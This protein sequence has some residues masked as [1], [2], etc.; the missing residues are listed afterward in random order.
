V[1]D[2]TT[3]SIIFIIDEIGM[4]VAAYFL[5]GI[6]GLIGTFFLVGWVNTLVKR[7]AARL[8]K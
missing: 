1:K 7:H 3:D 8:S 6:W 4:G 2:K 5:A